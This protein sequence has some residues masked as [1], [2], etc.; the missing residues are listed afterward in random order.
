MHCPWEGAY[1]PL[2]LQALYWIQAYKVADRA[3]WRLFDLELRLYNE[4]SGK[5]M[6]I[7]PV[8]GR[9]GCGGGGVKVGVLP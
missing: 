1:F 2:E 8:G 9:V 4:F 3:Y 6:G 7:V 5:S